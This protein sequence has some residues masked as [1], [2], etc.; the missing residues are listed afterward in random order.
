LHS[1]GVSFVEMN[2]EDFS[3]E[4]L[5]IWWYILC[6]DRPEHWGFIFQTGARI[7][8]FVTSKPSLGPT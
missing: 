6:Q 7:Y 5:Y 2:Q 3:G 4:Y 1:E 8:L